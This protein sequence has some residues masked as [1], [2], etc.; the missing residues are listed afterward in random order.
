MVGGCHRGGWNRA[1]CFVGYKYT[2]AGRRARAEGEAIL[3][4][5]SSTLSATIAR[6]YASVPPPVALHTLTDQQPSH[7]TM[8]PS[9]PPSPFHAA[10]PEF[11]RLQ[12]QINETAWSLPALP[13]IKRHFEKLESDL[14]TTQSLVDA[15]EKRAKD[16]QAKLEALQNSSFKRAWHRTRGDLEVKILKEETNS[17]QEMGHCLDAKAKIEGQTRDVDEAKMLYD[18]CLEA[19]AN[20]E[21]AR[22]ELKELLEGLFTG[23]TPLYPSEDELEESLHAA[24]HNAKKLRMVN[25]KN[26]YSLPHLRKALQY[27]REAIRKLQFDEE[28]QYGGSEYDTIQEV[29]AYRA[30]AAALI[31]AVH[32]FD[33]SLPLLQDLQLGDEPSNLYGFISSDL[34]RLVGR[35]RQNLED[36]AS[37][38]QDRILPP[39]RSEVKL[40]K[41]ELEK[42][43]ASIRSLDTALWAE[44]TRIMTE[45]LAERGL[46]AA[47]PFFEEEF[48][49]DDPPPA[50]SECA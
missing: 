9:S 48:G 19:V 34:H 16:R 49:H 22:K 27:I 36:G 29:C 25:M 12:L 2:P 28:I 20:N 3:G 10:A 13:D 17:V 26:T 24:R 7:A 39:L 21:T 35:I 1:W 33:P 8:P 46:V 6:L 4:T 50:Y 5:Q 44:R 45:L 41:E 38:L 37:V 40:V 43:Q 18:E 14:A 32:R 15:F 42:C 31:S 23:P 11:L 30:K 47:D